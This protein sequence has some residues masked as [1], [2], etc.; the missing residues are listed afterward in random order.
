MYEVVCESN[1]LIREFRSSKKKKKESHIES[2][3]SGLIFFIKQYIENVR[4]PHTGRGY[5]LFSL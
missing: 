4:E 3:G 5:Y 1:H 2:R